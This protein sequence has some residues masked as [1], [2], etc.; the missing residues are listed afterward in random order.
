MPKGSDRRE[1]ERLAAERAAQQAAANAA[2][3]TAS[4]PS[5]LETFL[6]DED[7][8]ILKYFSGSEGPVD[9]RNAPGMKAPNALYD[10][11]IKD[12]SDIEGIGALRLGT[13]DNSGYAS[14]IKQNRADRNQQQAAG[15]LENAVTQRIGQARGEAMPLINIS[16]D[17]NMGIAGLRSGMYEN[18]ANRDTQFRMRPRQP[19]FWRTLL[20]QGKQAAAT[21][22]MAGCMALDTLILTPSGFTE[23]GK[24]NEGDLV[25]GIDERGE[26]SSQP[27]TRIRDTESSEILQ[28]ENIR[29]RIVKVSPSDRIMFSADDRTETF[30]GE[31][32]EG[33]EVYGA[34]ILAIEKL[35]ERE[36]VRIIKVGSLY[37]NYGLLDSAGFTHLDDY[38]MMGATA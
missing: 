3:A 2:I 13:D 26:R 16:E 30:A 35:A 4:K 12:Q 5:E 22:A 8:S 7:L 20:E 34:T 19:S 32:E 15:R 6:S 18:A 9:V 23:I 28:I 14:L 24:L 21:K 11:A 29:G 36:P 31:L 17:R 38:R 10:S 37:A 1:E 25:I 27:I 33:Q